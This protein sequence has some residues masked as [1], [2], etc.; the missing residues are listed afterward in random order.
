[1]VEELVVAKVGSAAE[2]LLRAAIDLEGHRCGGYTVHDSYA[3]ALKEAKNP[4]YSGAAQRLTNF[5]PIDQ[6]AA[7]SVAL[8]LADAKQLVS[9]SQMLEAFGS[10][11]Y[12]DPRGRS[13]ALALMEVWQTLGSKRADFH[14]ELV[15]HTWLQPSVVATI[16]GSQQPNEIVVIGGHLDSIS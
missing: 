15:P 9:A 3:A 10:R 12:Q 5:P 2:P 13:A 8:E 4:H 6:Q 1:S 16:T 11:Y 7:V 14:V